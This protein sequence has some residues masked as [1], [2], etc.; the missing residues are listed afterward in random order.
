[1]PEP[2]VAPTT[3]FPFG[4]TEAFFVTLELSR[5]AELPQ[6]LDLNLS[7]EARVD[8]SDFPDK[9]QVGLRVKSPDESPLKV[10]L[11]LIGLFDRVPG[12]PEPDRSIIQDFV[13]ERAFYILWS[14]VEQTVRQTTGL[15]G[16]RPLKIKNPYYF[17]FEPPP[18]S[19]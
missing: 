13:N 11:E 8:D 12:Q 9:L 4:L 16:M 6:P 19:E 1:M 2:N 7:V 10:C 17:A 5:V 18:E 3:R 14:Y 15:M